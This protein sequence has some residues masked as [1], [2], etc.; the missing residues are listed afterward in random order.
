M[1]RDINEIKLLNYG[2]TSEN[3]IYNYV[4]SFTDGENR[5]YTNNNCLN[6]KVLIL[7]VYFDILYLKSNDK[8]VCGGFVTR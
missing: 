7:F 5:V 6:L 8:M 1:F 3:S 4:L 2:N